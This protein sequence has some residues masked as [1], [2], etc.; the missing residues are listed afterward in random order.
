[1]GDSDRS[2]LVAIAFHEPIIG[3]SAV[4]VLRVLPHLEERGWR[5]VFWA[6]GPGP[7]WD[8][9]IRRGYQVDGQ[10]RLLRYSRAALRTPPG[11][12]ARLRSVPGYL[13]HFRR[14]LQQQAPAVLHANTLIAIPEALTARASG[15]PVMLYVHE[16]IDVGPR[17]RVA[18]A[19]IRASGATVITNSAASLRALI[20]R[21]IAAHMVHYG[22]NLPESNRRHRT[23]SGNLVVGTLGTISH[24]KGSD[25]FLAAAE[26]VQAQLPGIEF[27]MVGPRPDGPEREWAQHM[28]DRAQRNAVIWSTTTDPFS[29]LA[30]WDLL[31]LPTRRE[32]FG[33]VL[34]EAMA[35]GL[36]VVSTRIDG[37]L[38]I[39]GPETGFLVAVGDS[40]A[41]AEKIVELASDPDRREAM[42]AAGRARVEQRFTL[43]KQADLIH[44][45]YL[46]AASPRGPG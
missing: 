41:L 13:S 26:R 12:S 24:R 4:A 17:A 28:I 16:L 29:E 2:R 21:G 1:M 19:M 25:V 44:E 5:F 9:L 27:R 38:E 10:E 45:A 31:V 43:Q 30:E 8:E 42:G 20:G 35:I 32:P 18:A 15:V 11:A 37:P 14:W 33:L 34:I 36:P 46:E 40:V 6:P 23:E 3:G 39:V 22:V 7:L